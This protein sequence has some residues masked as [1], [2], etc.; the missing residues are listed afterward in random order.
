MKR[1]KSSLFRV[2]IASTGIIL[3]LGVNT[4][5]RAGVLEERGDVQLSQIFMGDRPMMTTYGRGTATAPADTAEI[6]L[7]I[8]GTDPYAPYPTDPNEPIPQPE[9]LTDSQLQPIVDALIQAG[10]AANNIAVETNTSGP[11]YYLSPGSAVVTV[12]LSQPSQTLLDRIKNVATEAS[13]SAGLYYNYSNETCTL[14]NIEALEAQAR[15]LAIEDARSRIQAMAAAVGA[16]TTQILNMAEFPSFT[17]FSTACTPPL[18]SAGDRP[19]V[20][21]ELGVLMTYGVQ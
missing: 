7:Y 16:Q 20:S 2:A 13:S 21:I 9:N 15:G 3:G 17:P 12:K 11:P 8:N 14:E 18:G 1:L 5:I 4:P 6:Q 19:E 10:V